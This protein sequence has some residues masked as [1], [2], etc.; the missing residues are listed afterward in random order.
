ML[1]KVEGQHLSLRGVIVQALRDGKSL[2]RITVPD[3]IKGS[4]ADVVLQLDTKDAS[5]DLLHWVR[6]AA[7]RALNG[8]KCFARLE[9]GD[10]VE[11]TL[12]LQ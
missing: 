11:V 4:T 7:A 10:A 2:E 8:K 12:I 1:A 6:Q 3:I 5:G 9:T